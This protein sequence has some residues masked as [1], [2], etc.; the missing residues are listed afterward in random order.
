M[1]IYIE[2]ENQYWRKFKALKGKEDQKAQES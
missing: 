1:E 2:A